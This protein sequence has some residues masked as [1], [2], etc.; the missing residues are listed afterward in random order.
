MGMT[1]QER[2]VWLSQIRRIHIEQK[3]TRD[4]EIIEQVTYIN[5]LRNQ[6]TE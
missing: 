6:E 4:R 3:Q 1:M 5:N 2:R